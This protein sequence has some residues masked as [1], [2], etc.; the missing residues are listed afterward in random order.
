MQFLGIFA[1]VQVHYDDHVEVS[2]TSIRTSLTDTAANQW[3]QWL[4]NQWQQWLRNQWHQWLRKCSSEQTNN[5]CVINS[6][7]WA[8]VFTIC[9][10]S[11]HTVDFYETTQY[12]LK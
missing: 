1:W 5:I 7:F 11:N 3:Q 8:V 9:H 6:N 10:L 12:C 2:D 4:R